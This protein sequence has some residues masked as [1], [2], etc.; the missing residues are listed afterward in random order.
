M[1]YQFLKRGLSI[2]ELLSPSLKPGPLTRVF[3]VKHTAVA[4]HPPQA[5]HP[6]IRMSN[7]DEVEVPRKVLRPLY[8]VMSLVTDHY[9]VE[10]LSH[11]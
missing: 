4:N 8:P 6:R 11:H 3:L 9:A 1:L 2:R 7:S 10:G 5:K